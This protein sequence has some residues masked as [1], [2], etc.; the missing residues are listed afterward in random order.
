[1]FVGLICWDNGADSI[2]IHI[3]YAHISIYGLEFFSLEF[4]EKFFFSSFYTVE[5]FLDLF[6]VLD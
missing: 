6:N 3:S 2:T 4:V 1:M 5:T